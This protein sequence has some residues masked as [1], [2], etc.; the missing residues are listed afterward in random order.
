MT[1]LIHAF[2]LWHEDKARWSAQESRN[3]LL[4][5]VL[6]FRYV[7][8]WDKQLK[9]S[10][11]SLILKRMH[12]SGRTQQTDWHPP[13]YISCLVSTF[14]FFLIAGLQLSQNCHPQSGIRMTFPLPKASALWKHCPGVVSTASILFSLCFLGNNSWWLQD[15]QDRA[16][17]KEFNPNSLFPGTDNPSVRTLGPCLLEAVSGPSRVC[18]LWTRNAC[19]WVPLASS[20]S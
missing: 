7:Q 3:W 11:F 10:Y 15:K 14:F 19:P 2:C 13:D 6:L 9:N 5:L 18:V 16:W 1:S 8:K 12:T 20:G 4:D 17:Q